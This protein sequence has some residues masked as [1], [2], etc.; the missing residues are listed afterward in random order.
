MSRGSE[1]PGPP[2]GLERYPALV[3]TAG[4]AVKGA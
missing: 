2:G 1:Y 4:E 3:E